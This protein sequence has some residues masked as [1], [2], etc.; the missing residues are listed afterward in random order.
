MRVL[1]IDP[2]TARCGLA[3]SDEEGIL[4]TPIEALPVGDG[5][6]LAERLAEKA[7]ALGAGRILVGY[8]L[9]MD[10]SPGP[11]ARAVER[12]AARLRSVSNVPVDLVDERLT[13]VEARERLREAGRHRTGRGSRAGPAD[14]GAVDSA[15]AAILLQ[16]WLDTQRAGMP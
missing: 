5:A 3:V 6:R 8:P 9:R 13:T 14:R 2:G 10:G 15:A 1:A 7:R 4:A 11:R 16:G 12:L